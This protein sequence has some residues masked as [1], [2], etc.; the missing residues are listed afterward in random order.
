M[1]TRRVEVRAA[2]GASEKQLLLAAGLGKSH[3]VDRIVTQKVDRTS[4]PEG[5]DLYFYTIDVRPIG[6]PTYPLWEPIRPAPPVKITPLRR[7]ANKW[8]KRDEGN[9]IAL[10]GADNQIDHR[11]LD[12]RLY[13]F[14]SAR[15]MDIFLQAAQKLQPNE[16]LI[17]GDFLDL[18]QLG[19]FAQEASWALTMQVSLDYAK[20][21]L[22][23]LRAAA[24]DARIVII[25]GNHDKRM[26]NFVEA[27]FAAAYGLKR[28]AITDEMR[29]AWPV[30][31]LPYLLGLDE[32]SI[33]YVDAWPA[34]AFW[35]NART[36]AIHGYKA[37]SRGSTTAAYLNEAPHL[38]VLVGHTHRQEITWRSGQGELNQE[39]RSFSANPGA[40]CRI[41]G[42][43]PSVKG[44]NHADGTPAVVRENWQQGFI[45]MPYNAEEAWPTLVPIHDGRAVLPGTWDI[46][47]APADLRD[48]DPI[49][50]PTPDP[51]P[52]A[53]LRSRAM[54][55]DVL[56][57]EGK[58]AA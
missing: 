1:S 5:D 18:P 24:P 3:E 55:S 12:G 45:I 51:A 58:R 31:T 8:A 32:L 38:N 23:Q 21:W 44:A 17:L 10:I 52:V 25:E 2:A 28:A 27:N 37:N 57:R 39:L 29:D 7:A 19:R 48:E 53:E 46:L 43:V 54:V 41:D 42:S 11:L 13:A 49:D 35:L 33:D 16:I 9:G 20:T 50:L 26:N 34:A 22:A 4:D 15:A 14:H 40:L 36:K 6:D 56:A 47:E 30:M